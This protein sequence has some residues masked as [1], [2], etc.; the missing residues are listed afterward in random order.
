MPLVLL[1]VAIF[2]V[3]PQRQNGPFTEIARV[4][5]LKIAFSD[6]LLILDLYML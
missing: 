3:H 4:L 6:A 2:I 1:M 5:S